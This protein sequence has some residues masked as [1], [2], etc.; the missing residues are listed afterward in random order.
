MDL[1]YL[2]VAAA[3]RGYAFVVLALLRSKWLNIDALQKYIQSNLNHLI[4]QV[5]LR[6]VPARR[7]CCR[8]H[9]SGIMRTKVCLMRS[10]RG[11]L[12]RHC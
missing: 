5:S 3:I 11:L 7:V 4:F 9:E 2:H 8:K 10:G 6:F 1:K 12:K